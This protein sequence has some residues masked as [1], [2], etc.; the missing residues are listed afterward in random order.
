LLCETDTTQHIISTENWFIAY[1][2]WVFPQG[3]PP[4]FLEKPL[5]PQGAGV[6]A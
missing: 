5:L 1:F 4:F 3:T 2:T 6:F